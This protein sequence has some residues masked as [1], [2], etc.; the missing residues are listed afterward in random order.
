MGRPIGM[1]AD[2]AGSMIWLGALLVL[3]CLAAVSPVRCVPFAPSQLQVLLDFQQAWGRTFAG[4]VTGGNCSTATQVKCD[5]Q[6]ML[7]SMDLHNQGLSGSIPSTI[8]SMVSLTYLSFELNNLTGHL[9]PTM[10]SLTRLSYLNISDTK[11][12]CPPDYST[13]VVP[14]NASSAFCSMCTS[15]CATCAEAPATAPPSS[16]PPSSSPQMKL[17]L[18]FQQAWGRTFVGWVAGGNCSTAEYVECDAQGMVTSIFLEFQGLTGSIPSSISSMVSL[19][20][21]DLYGNDLSGSIPSGIANLLDLC[22]LSLGNNALTGSFPSSIA[23][24]SGLTYLDL[25][26]NAL[27]GS[28]P[29]TIANMS[30]LEYLNL[31]NNALTGFIPSTICSITSLTF[32]Y[33]GYNALT[34]PIPSTI[35]NMTNLTFLSLELNNLTGHLPAT[36][37]SLT[38]LSDLAAPPIAP[39]SFAPPSSAPP[40]SSPESESPIPPT[41]SPLGDLC[42]LITPLFSF[43]LTFLHALTPLG[44]LCPSYGLLEFYSHELCPLIYL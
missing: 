26:R 1:G 5:A 21:L 8:S 22:Y 43:V 35:S 23:S 37:G 11:I 9:P 14:Q 32:L 40:S 30:N 20:H 39:P 29:S 13:C 10:G 42:S 16:A 41:L 19:T 34:G 36:M 27:T 2:S 24:M 15:F 17:L 18:D 7:T 25:R 44:D 12:M 33:L 4:W 31:G 38:R 3:T 6:G 28:I